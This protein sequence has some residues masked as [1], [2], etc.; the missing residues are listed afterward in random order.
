V[1]FD[2][3]AGTTEAEVA[4]AFALANQAVDL[5]AETAPAWLE[6]FRAYVADTERILGYSDPLPVMRSSRGTFGLLGL[7]RR[8][9]PLLDELNLPPLMPMKW[10]HG[11]PEQ[12]S[13]T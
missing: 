12:A 11:A 10:R 7:L 1:T 3:F 6:R 8:W 13:T 5:N 2:F 9:A 4:A